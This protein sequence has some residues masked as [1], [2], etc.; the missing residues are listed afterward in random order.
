VSED[1][2]RLRISGGGFVHRGRATY[3]MR[4]REQVR[5]RARAPRY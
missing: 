2:P 1:E 3:R 5:R 4:R